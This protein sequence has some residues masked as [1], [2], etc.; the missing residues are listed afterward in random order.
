MTDTDDKAIYP[1]LTEQGF[2]EG[3][4][5]TFHDIPIC[6]DEQASW[7]YTYGHRDKD[8]FAAAVNDYDHE[9]AGG[10]WELGYTAED[11]QHLYAVTLEPADGP[12]GWLI[13]WGEDAQDHPRRFPVTVVPR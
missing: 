9:V 6:E 12:D 4:G 13:S 1:A 8:Q 10:D 5:Y 3:C 2:N 11:V 7:V